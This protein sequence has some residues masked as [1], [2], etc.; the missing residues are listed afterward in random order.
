LSVAKACR[1]DYADRMYFVNHSSKTVHEDYE[2]EDDPE[3]LRG[4]ANLIG[5]H[6]MSAGK[7]YEAQQAGTN[8]IS[9]ADRRA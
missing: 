1:V 3:V 7:I 9:L 5:N 8:V 6:I 2:R 4:A